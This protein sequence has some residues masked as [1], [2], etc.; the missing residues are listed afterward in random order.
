MKAFRKI[1]LA[2]IIV[3]LAITF[4]FASVAVGEVE[5][6][7]TVEELTTRVT[8]VSDADG[9]IA[10]ATEIDNVIAYLESSPVDPAA[11]GYA[12][13]MSL[14]GQEALVCATGY[15]ES[16][17]QAT[18]VGDKSIALDN[19]VK[20]A[21]AFE[22]DAD[23]YAAFLAELQPL[24]L[25]VA[26]ALVADVNVALGTARNGLAINKVKAFLKKHT[27]NEE[28][29]GYAAF[30]S[31]WQAKQDAQN[32]L[33]KEQLNEYNK[34]AALTDYDG[35]PYREID[36]SESDPKQLYGFTQ[37]VNET[38]TNF[39]EIRQEP[40]G[41]HYYYFEYNTN[42]HAYTRVDLPKYE[43]GTV[44]EFD[45]TTFGK[46]PKAGIELG[47]SSVTDETGVKKFPGYGH[48]SAQ[49]V[50]TSKTNKVKFDN[51][52]VPGEWT[53]I[54]M[55]YT[56]ATGQIDYYINYEL[57]GHDFGNAGILNHKLNCFR[58]GSVNNTD[59][60]TLY[61]GEFAIDNFTVYQGTTIRILDYISSMTD[62]ERFA[63]YCGILADP[64]SDIKDLRSAYEKAGIEIT[65]Y[66]D[67]RNQNYLTEDEALKLAVDQYNAFDYEPVYIA[68]Q[69]DNLA[70]LIA[71]IE[72]VS[73]LGRSLSNISE[74]STKITLVDEFMTSN[75]QDIYKG[76]DSEYSS[77]VLM[78]ANLKAYVEEDS[79]IV[80]FNGKVDRF[81]L[82]FNSKA[83]KQ[84]YD[85][86]ISLIEGV[87]VGLRNEKGYEAF[88]ERYNRFFDLD[89]DGVDT[90]AA[91]IMKE[92]I[93]RDNSRKIVECIDFIDEY[94]TT[95]QWEANFEFIDKY[96]VIVREAT[97][98][99][100][101]ETYEGVAE[102]LEFFETID[103]YFYERLQQ[104]H[105]AHIQEQ[106]DKYKESTS[107]IERMGLCAYLDNYFL[108]PSN[109]I[110]H[111]DERILKCKQLLEVYKSELSERK[112]D[113]KYYLEQ[114]T[115]FFKNTVTR[116]VL[117]TTYSE[118][119]EAYNEASI[120]YYAMNAGDDSVTEDILAFEEV[121]AKIKTIQEN[122]K[123]FCEAMALYATAGTEDERFLY[124]VEATVARENAEPE[125]EGVAEAIAEF[126]KAYN[127]YMADVEGTNG[128]L[129]A[130]SEIMAASRANSGVLPIV[131]AVLAIL[132]IE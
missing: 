106:L 132:G 97:K 48:I 105:I 85:S 54:T 31:D 62:E 118:M 81:Y 15:M 108:D 55:V 76:E 8:A 1:T 21:N 107:Y 18:Q 43:N 100:Y 77:Y 94:T 32:A 61:D 87:N 24:E 7:G 110:N 95:E 84:H 5:Y 47:H 44:I 16:A 19:A 93:S 38:T 111:N 26:E 114:N 103:G 96:I 57:V 126:E 63:Y 14:L 74:R 60:D 113:Y 49:G 99:D 79:A 86:C 2:L 30:A 130:A 59:E 11:E 102:A 4:V 13:Q 121:G 104:R 65:K 71:L 40:D 36:F 68:Y 52:I 123:S 73:G 9:Y 78:L 127:A 58:I 42:A 20:Y 92:A 129:D 112:E 125:V 6:T 119:L 39:F 72:D 3:L 80:Q 120:Y 22:T 131:S 66:W 117:A 90:S 56:T 35:A 109:D 101:D 34:N 124:L 53:R 64:D 89:G 83:M 12:L 88:L 69:K 98:G 91:T 115:V 46:L 33:V 29:D 75:G 41:N 50:F 122:S 10:K 67:A 128:D 28:L 27:L 82:A 51:V 70:K 23:E 17:A 116:M 25:E 45:I 37:S